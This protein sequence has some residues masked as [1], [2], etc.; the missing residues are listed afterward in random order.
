MF[1]IFGKHYG[2]ERFFIM[3]FLCLAVIVSMYVYAFQISNESKRTTIASTALYTKEYTWSRTSAKGTVEALYTNTD[4]TRVFMLLKN[5]SA[6]SF[7]AQEYSV[8]M[9]GRDTELVNDPKLA[10]YTYGASGYVGFYFTDAKGFANQVVS[11][12]VR[13]DSAASDYASEH[14]MDKDVERDVSFRDHNQIRIYANFGASEMKNLEILNAESINPLQLFSDTAGI[15]PDGT[16]VRKAYSEARSN[17][18]SLLKKMSDEK[19]KLAQY[20]ENLQVVNVIVPELPYYIKNDKINTT[21]NN[22]DNE[23]HQFDINMLESNNLSSAS[24]TN[25]LV[26]GTGTNNT[27]KEEID[28]TIVEGTGATYTDKDGNILNYYYLHTDYYYPGTAQFDWQGRDLSFGFITQLNQYKGQIDKSG[29]EAYNDYIVWQNG[30]SEF[31]NEM[32]FKI[33]YDSWRRVDGTYVDLQDNLDPTGA[34][35]LITQYETTLN[36]YLENKKDYF[37]TLDL[38]LEC[39][40]KLHRIGEAVTVNS[41]TSDNKNLYIY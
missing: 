31:V 37:E 7:D 8:Y 4:N 9:T 22:F 10:I 36:A 30:Y 12:I 38:I 39:E 34:P 28:T 26:Q 2:A 13:N 40:S 18:N 21:P 32:P 3:I 41:G 5:E 20:R 1:K 17:A 19:I 23:P 29:Y 16:D 24:G 15:L 27:E 14:N 33:D 35:T 11:L 6:T 25:F